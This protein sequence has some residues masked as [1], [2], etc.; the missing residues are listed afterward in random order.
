MSF[1]I[2]SQLRLAHYDYVLFDRVLIEQ[3]FKG[4]PLSIP[5]P[6]DLIPDA[7]KLPCLINIKSCTPV[8][9]FGLEDL[10]DEYH[11]L[12]CV[13]LLKTEATEKGL[14][15]F[16]A[17]RLLIKIDGVLA[18]FRFY[19]P[20]VMRHLEWIL[21]AEQ[22]SQLLGPIN[23]WGYIKENTI[24]TIRNETCSSSRLT[25][26]DKQQRLVSLIG[27]INNVVS[28]ASP[29]TSWSVKNYIQ[30]ADLIQIAED[31][32]R[33]TQEI[34]LTTFALHGLQA[35]SAF[36]THPILKEKISQMIREDDGY[37]ESTLDITDQDW[38]TIS[39]Q[40]IETK[41]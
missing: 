30:V 22:M 18:L 39:K 25:L 26:S 10:I 15:S 29:R 36:H 27:T 2:A 23:E 40:S 5:A 35:G 9:V 31:S 41:G 1:L 37:R 6:K 14:Q 13:A 16:L 11:H 21:S 7:D 24:H 4:Y 34:D 12:P 38:L 8:Q 28:A 32:Y 33:I 17:K 3:D 19:D 20:R